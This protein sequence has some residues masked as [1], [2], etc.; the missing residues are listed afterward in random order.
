MLRCFAAVE[1]VV[2]GVT[3]ALESAQFMLK[4]SFGPQDSVK[5]VPADQF[6][7]TLKYFGDIEERVAR[8]AAAVLVQIA[9]Q[10]APFTLE[11]VG[12][13][14]FPGTER[15]SVLWSGPG[16]GTPELVALANRVVEAMAQAGFARE[17]MPFKP[18]VTLGRVR[19]GALVPPAVTE[20]LKVG[21]SY[22]SWRV[23]RLV[24]MKSEPTPAGPR[25]SVLYDAPLREGNP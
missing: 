6:H 17:A 19:E 15:P 10:T 22:G 25:Y 4:R 16:Q 20:A 8:Q 2:P 3:R 12:L 11:V 7:F 9:A 24:L 14:A 18:H 1:V 21:G 13:G 23:E 5:W